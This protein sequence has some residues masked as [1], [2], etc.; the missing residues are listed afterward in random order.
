MNERSR[1][2]LE[3]LVAIQIVVDIKH[4]NFIP[5]GSVMFASSVWRHST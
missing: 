3:Q 1:K 5:L 2:V 4:F